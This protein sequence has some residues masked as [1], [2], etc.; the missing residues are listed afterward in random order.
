M[1]WLRGF[2]LWDWT[3][4]KQLKKEP[5]NSKLILQGKINFAVSIITSASTSKINNGALPY[6][7]YI[8]IHQHHTLKLS[9]FFYSL[10][11]KGKI[12]GI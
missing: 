6:S 10:S 8:W 3:R 1:N 12:L 5:L 2:F 4:L 11:V 9:Y 7:G